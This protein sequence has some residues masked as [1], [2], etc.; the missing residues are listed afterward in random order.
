MLEP[1]PNPLSYPDSSKVPTH[2]EALRMLSRAGLLDHDEFGQSTGTD[3]AFQGHAVKKLWFAYVDALRR[4]KDIP[5][6]ENP[7]L[8]CDPDDARKL[9][10]REWLNLSLTEAVPTEGGLA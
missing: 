2:A 6:V 5:T 7:P 1:P 9:F 8:N 4:L 3:F 10:L